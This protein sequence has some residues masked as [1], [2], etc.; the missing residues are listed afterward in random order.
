MGLQQLQQ[1]FTLI[2]PWIAKGIIHGYTHPASNN[3]C[4]AARLDRW[5]VSEA[6]L[7]WVTRVERKPGAPGDHHGVLLELLIPDL[8]KLGRQGWSFPTYLLFH[9]GLLPQLEQEVHN[10][11]QMIIAADPEADTRDRWEAIKGEVRTTADGLHRR[12]TLQRKGEVKTA[13]HAARIAL[14][15]RDTTNPASSAHLNAIMANHRLV[16]TISQAGCQKQVAL[17]AAYS[18][19]GERGSSWFH[20]LGREVKPAPVLT[21]LLTPGEAHP[22]SLNGPDVVDNISAAAWAHYSSDSP[23]GLFRIGEVDEGAQEELLGHISRRLTEPLRLATEAQES[24]GLLTEV[25]IV[26]ALSGS[27]NGKAPGSDG[28]PYELYKALWK[29]LG[30][31]LLAALESTFNAVGDLVGTAAAAQLPCSWLEG[32]ISLIYKGRELPRAQLPSYRPITLLNCDYKLVGKAINNR[33]QP[34]IS[35]LI[36]ELQTAF[37]VGRWIGDNVLYHQALAEWL[38]ASQQPGALLLLDIQQAYD[39]VHRPWL[40][41]VIQAMGFGPLMQRWIRLL[42]ADGLARLVVNGHASDPFQVHNGLQQGSTLSPVLW[43]LQLEPLTA[44]LHDM[45]AAGTL[46]TPKMPNGAPASPVSHHADDTTL[47]VSDADIDGLVAKQAVSLYCRASNAKE[48]ASKAKGVV[49]G[50]H[51]PIIGTHPAT[52]AHFPD[53]TLEPP[54]HLGIPIGA[55]HS[56]TT[57]A[58]YRAR[59]GRMKGLAAAWWRHNLSMVGRVHVAKQVLGN[60]L[61]YH[62]T[63]VKPTPPQMAALRQTVNGYVAWS[64][65]PED[66]SLVTHGRAV[67]LPEEYLACLDTSLGGINHVHLQAFQQA[68][69]AKTLAQLACPGTQPWKVLHRAILQHYR[70]PGTAG[71]G[72][73]YGTAPPRGDLPQRLTELVQA[74]RETEPHRIPHEEFVDPRALL[75]EALFYNH[76]LIDPATGNPFTHPQPLPPEWPLT[77]GQLRA[78]PEAIQQQPIMVAIGNAAPAGWRALCQSG[79]IAPQWQLPPTWRLSPSCEWAA[80]ADGSIYGVHMTGRLEE[81]Q[82]V[83]D[84]PQPSPDWQPACIV[85]GR[86]PRLFWTPQERLAYEMAPMAE[87][88]NTWPREQQVLGTWDELQ[89]FPSTYGH[90]SISLL[91]YTVCNTRTQVTLM[92]AKAQLQPHMVP[93]VPAAWRKTTPEPGPA[94]GPLSKLQTME[95]DWVAACRSSSS[96]RFSQLP[97]EL[98]AWLSATTTR[99][100]HRSQ[101]LHMESAAQQQP[102]QQAPQPQGPG[103]PDA[104]ENSTGIWKHL[105]E[106][107]ASNRAKI[108][109]WRLQHGRLPCGLYLA[110]K[111]NKASDQRQFCPSLGCQQQRP[112]PRCSLTH[113]FLHC[114]V[115]TAARHWLQQLWGAITGGPGPPVDN[116]ELMLGDR[117]Q[118]WQQYPQSTSTNALWQA[119]RLTFLHA[120]WIVHSDTHVQTPTSQQ[121]VGYTVQEL[122]R[123]M[124]TQ[125]RMAAL[126][127]D[128][129]NSLPLQLITAQLKETQL[130]V[131]KAV[132][133]TGSILCSV[134][135]DPGGRVKLVVHLSMQHPIAVPAQVVLG[136]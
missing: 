89:C 99:P 55:T 111:A 94:T 64:R 18:Q 5:L 113:T 13:L 47:L 57:D 110:S 107:P 40:Y 20:R 101:Q 124:R 11:I 22:R 17:E 31:H 4:S 134:D 37:A 109:V 70:P 125:F 35:H 85:L 106:C 12:H 50:T 128:T 61:A 43:V 14:T 95:V 9:P 48:N 71:W 79:L 46:H 108:L 29:I 56:A 93:V 33:L 82:L 130:D 97:P 3:R 84:N 58:C 51:H 116:M 62:F 23:T 52:Q 115:Y 21:E 80:D 34:A 6:V 24:L 76:S 75:H 63:F 129:L 39:R 92:A 53:P 8:P 100:G 118:A 87:K 77:L 44:F 88:A 120:L 83:A 30:P 54:R 65:L 98:P 135:T 19:Q 73:V 127:E 122:Q 74:F 28:L 104:R 1:E 26:A 78:A 96:A 136:A 81:V 72:W 121:V 36:D 15:A 103:P 126:S 132:W 67:L 2:D 27:A 16:E 7:P 114:P 131:F 91:H 60:A 133:A 105:W 32:L 42:T 90:G 69:Q 68:L 41:K 123:L 38:N 66:V 45:V 117:P 25:E 49:L 119:I 102:T 86:K 10:R 59:I 112:K